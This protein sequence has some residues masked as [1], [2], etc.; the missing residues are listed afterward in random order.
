MN[1]QCSRKNWLSALVATGAFLS[2]QPPPPKPN[3]AWKQL[4]FVIGKWSGFA[5]EKDTPLGAGQGAFSFEP[6]L[7]GKIIVRRN[8]ATY[9]SGVQHDDLLV[10]YADPPE[11]L[12]RAIYFDSEGHTIRYN[13]K[14]PAANSVVFESDGSQPGPRYRLSYWMEASVMKGRFE[15]APPGGDYKA[16]MNWGAKRN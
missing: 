11:S 10:I 2:A 16:Y 9:A 8:N 1:M 13:L 6:E 7:G 5:G 15:V 14:F 3:A 12:P 4:D